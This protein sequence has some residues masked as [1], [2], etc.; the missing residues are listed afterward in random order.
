MEVQSPLLLEWRKIVR[1]L[2]K[3]W[4]DVY[5]GMRKINK[6]VKTVYEFMSKDISVEM[7]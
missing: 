3:V 5:C 2:I 7:L 6:G 1:H 4:L